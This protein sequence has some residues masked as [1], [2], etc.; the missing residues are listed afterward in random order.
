LQLLPHELA[1]MGPQC[2]FSTKVLIDV[3]GWIYAFGKLPC[4]RLSGEVLATLV[5]AAKCPRCRLFVQVES[6]PVEISKC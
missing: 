1:S 3:F 4:N 6:H 5:A 2:D